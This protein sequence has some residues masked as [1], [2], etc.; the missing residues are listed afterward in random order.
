MKMLK[1]ETKFVKHD[2]LDVYMYSI[3]Y[4]LGDAEYD[5]AIATS[6][7]EGPSNEDLAILWDAVSRHIDQYLRGAIGEKDSAIEEKAQ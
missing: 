3:E 2:K 1:V 7:A 5:S 6:S 4:K